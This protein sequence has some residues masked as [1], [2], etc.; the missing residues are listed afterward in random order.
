MNTMDYQIEIEHAIRVA[1]G[2]DAFPSEAKSLLETLERQGLTVLPIPAK[3]VHDI[4]RLVRADEIIALQSKLLKMYA[5]EIFS[6]Q[7]RIV[8]HRNNLVLTYFEDY[9]SA[10][11]KGKEVN[12]GQ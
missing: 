8:E 12:D 3:Q 2:L 4:D 6:E 1:T 9:G 7:R 11:V 5:S 10:L